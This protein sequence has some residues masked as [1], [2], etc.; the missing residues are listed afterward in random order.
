MRREPEVNSDRVSRVEQQVKGTEDRPKRI[1]VSGNREI[2]SVYG[3]PED[4][5]ARWVN[6]EPGRIDKFLRAGY[7]FW[8]DKH[9]RVGER[10]VNTGENIGSVT[11]LNVGGGVVAYLMVLDRDLYEQDQEAKQ[12]VINAQEAAMHRKD[13]QAIDGYGDLNIKN[14]IRS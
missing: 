11:T 8:T 13:K 1:P 12:N 14:S 5:Y 7:T 10:T 2:L 6:D 3:L 9:I 4:L